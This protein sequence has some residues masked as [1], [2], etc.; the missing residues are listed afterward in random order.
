M[1]KTYEFVALF[2]PELTEQ[3]I[4]VLQENLAKLFKKHKGKVM[5]SEVWGKKVLAYPI[6]KLTEAHYLFY[7]LE[8]DTSVVQAF[9]QDIRLSTEAIR[10]LLII[11]EEKPAVNE[12][13]PAVQE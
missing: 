2:S 11:Q 8:L 12:Q 3:D 10:H 9:D 5:A 1:I 4:Q 6:K 13:A 7:T